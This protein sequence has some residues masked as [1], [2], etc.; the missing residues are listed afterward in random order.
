M[1]LPHDQSCTYLPAPTPT[2]CC[3]IGPFDPARLLIRA[4]PPQNVDETALC[5]A[6]IGLQLFE[7]DDPDDPVR[8]ADL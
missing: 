7:K 2:L 5:V 6:L 4:N 8:S 1:E 3:V